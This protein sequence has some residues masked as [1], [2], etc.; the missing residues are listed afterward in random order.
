V[1]Q[2]DG[3]PEVSHALIITGGML[4]VIGVVLAVVQVYGVRRKYLRWSGGER[5]LTVAHLQTF[6]EP[7]DDLAS[8]GWKWGILSVS[9]IVAGIV[10][11]TVGAIVH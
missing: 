1:G 11:T 5:Q 3:T 2:G 4:Q 9:L 6:G 8:G 7:L 10:C